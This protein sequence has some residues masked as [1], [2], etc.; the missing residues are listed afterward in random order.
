MPM[1]WAEVR[2]DLPIPNHMSNSLVL[3]ANLDEMVFEGRETR[4]GAYVLRK[5]YPERLIAALVFT[6]LAALVFT[7]APVILR[8]WSPDQT[9]G[10]SVYT[11]PDVATIPVDQPEETPEIEIP[12]PELPKPVQT[13]SFLIPEP[14]P[15]EDLEDPAASIKDIETVLDAK[16]L[17]VKDVEGDD[18]LALFPTQDSGE[19]D[20]PH[21][22]SEQEP[23]DGIFIFAEE[24]PVPLNLEEV[25]KAIGY[26]RAALD[27]NIEGLVVVRILVD[28]TGSYSRHKLIN[29]GNPLLSKAV[30]AELHR[31]HFTPA[32][33]GGK[34]IA[35]WVNIPF[36]FSQVQ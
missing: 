8:A 15:E 31:L 29:T 36:K 16:N 25:K 6:S 20:V 9:P 14:T 23:S 35:F 7:F 13:I 27:A 17:G 26:P 22:I 2:P 18:V 11:L 4:Y 24:E 28:K 5:K 34:P 19:G 12:K 10:E 30:E 32:I 33:Q 1:S 3:A 21:V